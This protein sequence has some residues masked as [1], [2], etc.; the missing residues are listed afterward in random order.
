[1]QNPMRRFRRKPKDTLRHRVARGDVIDILAL[2]WSTSR[3][4]L[5]DQQK[6]TQTIESLASNGALDRATGG[7]V[8]DGLIEGWH[9][10]EVAEIE[11]YYLEHT[12]PMSDRLIA[13]AEG[14]LAVT[15][16]GLGHVVERLQEHTDVS[17]RAREELIGHVESVRL[18]HRAW[19]ESAVARQL[20]HDEACLVPNDSSKKEDR[21]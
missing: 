1:M 6:V 21:L 4:L 14:A 16:E 7:H 2:T 5:Q 17:V 19:A 3:S 11:S 10:A 9:A 15:R 13:A 20:P 12:V 18:P 8:V